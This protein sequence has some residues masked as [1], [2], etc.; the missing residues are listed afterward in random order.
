MINSRE[1]PL[2]QTKLIPP[3]MR[4]KVVH[5][6]ALL[7]ALDE[8]SA[9]GV[10]LLSSPA[11]YGKTT[12]VADWSENHRKGLGWLTLDKNDNDLFVLN[13]YIEAL[14][15]NALGEAHCALA[16]PNDTDE[17]ANLRNLLVSLGNHC[18][19][20]DREITLVLDDYQNIVDDRIHQSLA[21]L[22]AHFPPNLRLILLSRKDPP[23]SLSKLRASNNLLELR[24]NQMALSF[25]E[26]SE[27]LRESRQLDLSDEDL[28]YAYQKTEGWIAG[29]QLLTPFQLKEDPRNDGK[30][31]RHHINLAIQYYLLDEVV[32]HE[33]DDVQEFL[34]KTSF[35]EEIN[36]Q[37]C[38]CLL[39]ENHPAGWSAGMMQTL[40]HH[41]LFLFPVE[42]KPE[43]YRYHPL[44]AYVL[45]GQLSRLLPG[46]DKMLALRAS[47]W[48][49]N[50]GLFIEALNQVYATKDQSLI[51]DCLEKVSI[52][53]ILESEILEL[54]RLISNTDEKLLASS[55]LLSLAHAW[56]LLVS[57]DFESA[58]V[59]LEKAGVLKATSEGT[60]RTEK[61]S[62]IFDGMFKIVESILAASRGESE[63]AEA[64]ITEALTL[65]PQENYFA[66]GF[67]LMNHGIMHT[68][69]G[70]YAEAI[71]LYTETIQIGQRSG[72]WFVQIFSRLQLG[73]LLEHCGRLNEAVMQ[74]ER[75]LA[76]LTRLKGK[77]SDF[78]AFIFKELAGIHTA[79]NELSEA[80]ED[81]QNYLDTTPVLKA[82]SDDVS[83]HLSMA[84]FH[85]A[86]NDPAAAQLELNF[87]RQLSISS[88]STQDDYLVDMT[89]LEIDLQ[90]NKIENAEKWFKRY[91]KSNLND[92]SYLVRYSAH[93]NWARLL[94]VQGRQ[95]KSK[96]KLNQ[97]WEVLENLLPS[98]TEGGLIAHQ[99]KVHILMAQLANELADE[100]LMLS[101]LGL[102][103]ALAEP[104]E[105]RQVFLDEGI[106][107]SRLLIAY[108][109]AMKQNR[110]SRES[111][112]L[113]F[114]SDLS[115]RFTGRPEGSRIGLTVL[116]QEAMK[117]VLVVDLLTAR[118]TEV[119]ELVARGRSNS[120]IAQD[121]CISINT[122]KRHLNNVFM[123]LGVTTRV[124]AIRVARQRGIIT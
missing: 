92:F 107:M 31:R 117:D 84:R 27:F 121:L 66:H 100:D 90:H 26:T 99:I 122:V 2:I 10:V 86:N 115:F 88:E 95:E 87:A 111:P 101:E 68:I 18:A 37:L 34:I 103:L 5:R 124:Q 3:R 40:L 94:L 53:E 91:K 51:V 24:A 17:E 13:R 47:E 16:N 43:W 97:S 104:E 1:E 63:R 78:E 119:L 14:I 93:I 77:F 64:L 15:G 25:S 89:E 62:K 44:F 7:E 41:N 54:T 11:G 57:Y 108:M 36:E 71:A 96:A 45:S 19:G 75:S 21:F 65:L 46:Q 67:A 102:A 20:L 6:R 85:H 39:A 116:E 42:D 109:A 29:L 58:E 35:L 23:F 73:R 76:V 70:N 120:E 48:Y 72:N 50:Q 98:L 113:A 123:K 38:D 30:P 105:L 118:E 9:Q 60:R 4:N 52:K 22:L 49:E 56:D 28:L 61:Y 80:E 59:W 112:N 69:A 55:P 12:L 81:F 8:S 83:A 74:F 106:I 110:V 82:S 79:R 33:P 32:N 114:V